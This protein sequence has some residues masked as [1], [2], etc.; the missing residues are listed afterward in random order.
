VFP[1]DTRG[2]QGLEVRGNLGLRYTLAI[3]LLSFG[4]AVAQ[5]LRLPTGTDYLNTVQLDRHIGVLEA[6][7]GDPWVYRILS[8]YLVIPL[9]AAST[10]V[11]GSPGIGFFMFRVLQNSVIGVLLVWWVSRFTCSPML[12]FAGF[13]LFTYAQMNAV[14]DSDASL[15][16]YSEVIALLATALLVA[17][18]HP[19]LAL[20]AMVIGVANRETTL[21]AAGIMALFLPGRPLRRFV[22]AAASLLTG[23]A[24]VILIRLVVGKRDVIEPYGVSLGFEMFNYNLRWDTLREVLL[25]FWPLLVFAVLGWSLAAWSLRWGAIL[26]LL[27]VFSILMFAAIVAETRLLLPTTAVILVPLAALGIQSTDSL[28][29]TIVKRSSVD[30]LQNE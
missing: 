21:V 13:A 14:Y 5:V 7:A 26:I 3:V 12:G 29:A 23:V 16:T 17:H 25:T 11:T 6:T 4:S 18:N 15:N 8:E 28:K 30:P 20:L 27:P 24:T 22:W 1:S 2:Y 19:A 10:E 9:V